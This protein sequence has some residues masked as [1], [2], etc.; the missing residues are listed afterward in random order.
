MVAGQSGATRPLRRA[1]VREFWT[2]RRM[3]RHVP[4]ATFGACVRAQAYCW[5]SLL[6]P[7]HSSAALHLACC[8]AGWRKAG[9]LELA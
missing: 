3:A 9:V 7:R 1:Q 2:C 8:W 6:L 4:P 5:D